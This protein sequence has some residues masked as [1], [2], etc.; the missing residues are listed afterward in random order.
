MS[1]FDVQHALKDLTFAPSIKRVDMSRS[2]DQENGTY[3]NNSAT[4]VTTALRSNNDMYQTNAMV[5][6]TPMSVNITTDDALGIEETKSRNLIAFKQSTNSLL[7]GLIL[8]V[9]DKPLVGFTNL[10]NLHAHFNILSAYGPDDQEINGDL[11]GCYKDDS[12][13][14]GYNAAAN[15]NG[16]GESTNGSKAGDHQYQD[17]SATPNKTT[18]TG[19]LKV[20]SG[21]QKR[22]NQWDYD[23]TDTSIAKFT[24][25]GR[26]SVL[27]KTFRE[28]TYVAASTS[29]LS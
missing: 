21:F 23:E 9:D 20:N 1:E 11:I 2:R 4:I 3:P 22:A 12:G 13:S 15:E 18:Y 29:H 6:S 10:S 17:N 14:Y 26:A 24:T 19:D 8:K 16:I 7:N 5:L 25:V 27:N 28:K